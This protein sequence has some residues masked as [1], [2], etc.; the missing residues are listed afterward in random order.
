MTGC[1]SY[2]FICS[3]ISFHDLLSSGRLVLNVSLVL[4]KS[5]CALNKRRSSTVLPAPPWHVPAHGRARRSPTPSLLAA[6][7]PDVPVQ[8]YPSWWTATARCHHISTPVLGHGWEQDLETARPLVRHR[9]TAFLPTFGA[10]VP[11][12]GEEQLA[13]ERRAWRQRC[14]KPLQWGLP[15][16]IRHGTELPV[17]QGIAVLQ[18]KI[19]E[20][21]RNQGIRAKVSISAWISKQHLSRIISAT[22]KN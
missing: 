17:W 14:L 19:K 13:E 4:N 11:Q 10:P 9:A 2:Y 20:S 18:S 5:S 21:R 8:T 16:P 7:Q 6:A 1:H 12:T 22:V 3:N 15:Q